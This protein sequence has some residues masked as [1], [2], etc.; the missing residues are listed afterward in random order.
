M[1][2]ATFI[3]KQFHFMKYREC[4]YALV[5]YLVYLFRLFPIPRISHFLLLSLI[6][7][8]LS[9]FSHFYCCTLPNYA[10]VVNTVLYPLFFFQN[11]PSHPETT[12]I[13]FRNSLF[14]LLLR[15]HFLVPPFNH[16]FI[17]MESDTDIDFSGSDIEDLFISNIPESRGGRAELNAK[18]DALDQSILYFM[19]DSN[20]RVWL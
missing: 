9:F 8:F 5:L 11:K 7:I 1:I 18:N 15:L 2:S 3:V 6:V 14:I 12:P 13:L 16:S 4:I 20:D 19:D 17:K 10:D